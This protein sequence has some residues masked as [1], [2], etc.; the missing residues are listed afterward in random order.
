[1][2]LR[3]SLIA[4]V[5]AAGCGGGDAEPE[6]LAGSPDATRALAFDARGN[7]VAIGGT[8]T[9]GLAFVH[10]QAG[11]RWVRAAGVAGFGARAQL[12]GGG[13]LPLYALSE[14]TLYRLDD[15]ALYAWSTFPIPPGVTAGTPVGVDATGGEHAAA[16]AAA[17]HEWGRGWWLG[18][19]LRDF[20]STWQSLGCAAGPKT[21]IGPS[22]DGAGSYSHNSLITAPLAERWIG[23]P[24]VGMYCLL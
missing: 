6:L 19:V 20:L 4:V 17:T 7:P 16:H 3:R 1:M 21:R 18:C 12:L 24:E 22:I 23:R 10:H 8:S 15:P 5:L 9:F 11:D 13:T 2:V 14:S